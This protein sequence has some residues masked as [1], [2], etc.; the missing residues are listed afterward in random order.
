MP[1]RKLKKRRP[2]DRAAALRYDPPQ[3]SRNEAMEIIRKTTSR[4]PECANTVDGAVVVSGGKAWL[5]RECPDHGVFQL[6]LSEHGKEYADL[7]RFYSEV[8]DTSPSPGRTTNAW[9]LATMNCQQKCSYCCTESAGKNGSNAPW[10]EMTWDDLQEVLRTFKNGKISFGGG[11]PTLHPNMFDF[12]CEADRRGIAV[13][14]ATNGLLLASKEYCRRLKDSKVREVRLSCEA[15]DRED[16]AKLG[17]DR[18]VEPKLKAIQ[19]LCD[20]GIAVT[21]SPTICKGVN[22]GQIH[23]IIEYAKD[24]PG[25]QAFSMQ[26][27]AWTGCGINLSKDMVMTPDEMMDVIHRHY[28][29]C[30]RSGVFALQKLAFALLNVFG[31]ESCLRTEFMVLVRER[32]RLRAITDFVNLRRLDKMLNWWRRILPRQRWLRGVCLMPVLAGGMSMRTLPLI[33]AVLRLIWANVTNLSVHQYPSRLLTVGLN[34]CCST[35]NADHAVNAHCVSGC[36]FKRDGVLHLSTTSREFLA[37]TA[38]PNRV[39]P[40]TT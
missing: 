23:R 21:L 19:N 32:D 26:G 34:T 33:P 6:L 2:I 17:L 29:G 4:C 31:F 15:V 24:K 35:L 22:E 3:V 10:E 7:D 13:Q 16:A 9:L 5:R 1:R 36:I 37:N 39:K 30:D 40:H 38:I 20:L 14:L 27:F 12:F 11:E 18:H 25:I 28:C 8:Y